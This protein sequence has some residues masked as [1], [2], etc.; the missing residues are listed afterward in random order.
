LVTNT[1]YKKGEVGFQEVE[2]RIEEYLEE[3]A[4]RGK[5][6]KGRQWLINKIYKNMLSSNLMDIGE[7]TIQNVDLVF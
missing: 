3:L 1:K 7:R 6:T 5:E 4:G 2:K